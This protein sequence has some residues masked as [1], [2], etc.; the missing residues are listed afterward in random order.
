ME[1][2][3]AAAGNGSGSGGV[4]AGGMRGAGWQPPSG[5]GGDIATNKPKGGAV[6][7]NEQPSQL[8][9]TLGALN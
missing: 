8:S 9:A 3:R 6:R 4:Q 7:F 1:F 5:G 2:Y